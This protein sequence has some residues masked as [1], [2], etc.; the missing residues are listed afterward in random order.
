MRRVPDFIIIGA[1][2]CATSTLH[3]QL[4][5]QPGFF[6]STP[7]E[8]CFFSDDEVYARGLDW[9]GDLFAAAGPGD[10]CGESSTHYTKL[11]TYPQTVERI[12]RHVPHARLIYVMRDPIERLVSQYVHEWTERTVDG[13]IDAALQRYPRLVDYGRYALQL[14][15]YFEAF[16]R[17]RVLPVFQ[18]SLRARGQQELDRVCEFLGYPGRPQWREDLGQVN[19][20]AQRLRQSAWRDRVIN[21]PGLRQARRALVPRAVRERVK[22]LWMLDRPRL[23]D[24]SLRMLREVYDSDLAELGSWLGVDLSCETFKAVAAGR[25]LQWAEVSHDAR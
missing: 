8:P 7:K 22:R 20:S 25:P 6:M 19:V 17:E 3:E 9:Y 14:R 23:S 13:P 21:L 12:A 11:P 1:M 16:G 18:E 10:L 15:P 5:A 2:K 4:A 24:A